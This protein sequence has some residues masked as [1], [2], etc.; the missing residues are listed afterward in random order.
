MASIVERHDATASA[1]VATKRWRPALILVFLVSVLAALWRFLP[2]MPAVFYGDDLDYLLLFKDGQCATRAAEILTTTCYERF[3]P[4]ASGVVIAMMNLFGDRIQAFLALNVLI[5]GVIGVL[6]FAIARRL[7]RGNWLVALLIT[8]AVVMSRFATYQV[9]QMIGPVESLTLALCLGVVY[10]AVRADA[11]VASAWR[12]SWLA[13]L[14]SFLAMHSHERSMVTAIWLGLVFVLSPNIRALP[15]G[16]WLALLASC[17]ALP[18]YYIAF[19]TYVLKAYFLIGAGGTHLDLGFPLI[20]EHTTEAIRSLFGF[21]T[22]PDYLVGASVSRA[23][24]LAWRLALLF[25]AGWVG[26]L[27]VGTRDALVATRQTPESA[28]ARLRWPLLL[29][30]L[31][32]ALLAPSLLT[33]RLEQRWLLAPFVIG[34]LVVAW[35]AGPT[36]GLRRLRVGLVVVVCLA[37]LTLDTAV[38]QYF[39]RIFFI[40][41]PRFAAQVKH[42][43]VDGYPAQHGGVDLLAGADQCSWTLKNGGFFRLYGGRARNAQCFVSV[44]AA[45]AAGLAADTHIYGPDAQNRLTD[46]TP[47]P[48]AQVALPEGEIQF[49]FLKHFD[50]G[51]ISDPRHVSTPTGRGVLAMPWASERGVR[52]T[53]TVISGFSYRYDRIDVPAGATLRFAVGMIYPA[54]QPARA[55]VQVDMAGGATTNIYAQPLSPPTTDG[56]P[57]FMEVSLPLDAYAGKRISLSFA[58]DS[59]GGNSTAHWV[60]FAS[61][62][63]AKSADH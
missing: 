50:A 15:R 20:L 49:D 62:R 57:S 48:A 41:S 25:S 34:L 26:V 44:D 58:V 35:A 30:A 38:M 56:K 52:D 8:L 61:P 21:N 11:D 32:A 28:L 60:G 10:S 42:D 43:I 2:W 7:S 29:L 24:P 23:W 13:L 19:K 1:P 27:A 63:L 9:T 59:P 31:A 5:Q 33:T 47:K 46:L 54:V 14:F 51:Q 6:V 3:R 17:V 16:R 40:S 39:D 53:L 37:S 4:V 22:G 12:W 36:G 55:L 18:V 45:V